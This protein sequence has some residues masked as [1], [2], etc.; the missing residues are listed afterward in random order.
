MD[1]GSV[2]CARLLCINDKHCR[3]A[4]Q[5]E[6]KEGF[7]VALV[8]EC[9]PTCFSDYVSDWVGWWELGEFVVD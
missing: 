1:T 3:T 5:R 7:T 2:N 9:R 8:V 4:Q 6:G